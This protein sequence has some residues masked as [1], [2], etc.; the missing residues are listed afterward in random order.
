MRVSGVGTKIGARIER[1]WRARSSAEVEPQEVTSLP[2]RQF[3]IPALNA[4]S[5]PLRPS[6][7]LPSVDRTHTPPLDAAFTVLCASAASGSRRPYP[8]SVFRGY[9]AN[10]ENA[11]NPT[12]VM[13]QSGPAISTV[14]TAAPQACGILPRSTTKE[15]RADG[16]RALSDNFQ[17]APGRQATPALAGSEGSL[18]ATAE[19]SEEGPQRGGSRGASRVRGQGAPQAWA[20]IGDLPAW[21]WR[22]T[23][24]ATPFLLNPGSGQ[25]QLARTSAGTGAKPVQLHAGQR[26]RSQGPVTFSFSHAPCRQR[27]RQRRADAVPDSTARSSTTGCNGLASALPQPPPCHLPRPPQLRVLAPAPASPLSLAVEERAGERATRGVEP[28]RDHEV[29]R[30]RVRSRDAGWRKDRAAV[31][32]SVERR[33]RAPGGDVVAL[34]PVRRPGPR[35]PVR[36]VS[37]LGGIGARRPY[38]HSAPRRGVHGALHLAMVEVQAPVPTLR[39]PRLRGEQRKGVESWRADVTIRASDLNR[40]DRSAAG[41]RH[42]APKHDEGRSCGRASSVER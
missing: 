11:L 32:R 13:S 30:E 8:H 38:P 35:L 25:G 14:R 20:A 33:G 1:P 31:A 22:W 6:A 19:V 34:T 17:R 24:I 41:V 10:E 27:Q 26:R 37:R 12:V 23:S 42:P 36:A 15:G 3:V 29:N 40:E 16:H 2:S 39:L 7:G 5:S 9:A 28:G 4:L 21:S 18:T